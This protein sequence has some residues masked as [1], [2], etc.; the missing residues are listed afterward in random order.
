MVLKKSFAKPSLFLSNFTFALTIFLSFISELN[1]LQ[2]A[3]AISVL[4]SKNKSEVFF[5]NSFSKIG[6][7]PCKFTIKSYFFF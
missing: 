5:I 2:T 4:L 6:R 1:K 7:S 3:E